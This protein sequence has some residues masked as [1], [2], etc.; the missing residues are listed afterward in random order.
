MPK[1]IYKEWQILLG[2]HLVL[3]SLHKKLKISIEQD[4]IGDTKYNI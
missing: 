3:L 1:K 2:L 4:G